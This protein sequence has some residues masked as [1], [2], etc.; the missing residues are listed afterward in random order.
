[1]PEIYGDIRLVYS[2]YANRAYCLN[3]LAGDAVFSVEQTIEQGK[4]IQDGDTLNIPLNY[5]EAL[6]YN[7]LIAH[8]KARNGYYQKAYF[9]ITSYEY[10]NAEVCAITIELDSVETFINFIDRCE[11]RLKRAHAPRLLRKTIRRTTGYAYKYIISPDLFYTEDDPV[12]NYALVDKEI[13]D[14]GEYSGGSAHRNA[15]LLVLNLAESQ[16]QNLK[17]SNRSGQVGSKYQICCNPKITVPFSD[18]SQALDNYYWQFSSWHAP[19]E[20]YFSGNLSRPGTPYAWFATQTYLDFEWSE[21][22]SVENVITTKNDL[23]L[24]TAGNTQLIALIITFDRDSEEF[25]LEGGGTAQTITIR[26]GLDAL[27]WF[28]PLLADKIV[29]AVSIP[30]FYENGGNTDGLVSL[31]VKLGMARVSTETDGSEP[32]D[33]LD[34]VGGFSGLSPQT[35]IKAWLVKDLAN[36]SYYLNSA[37]YTQYLC[38]AIYRQNNFDLTYTLEDNRERSID[39]ELKLKLYPYHF[40]SVRYWGNNI[41]YKYQ[42]LAPV[43]FCDALYANTATSDAYFMFCPFYVIDPLASSPSMYGGYPAQLD[44]I[45]PMTADSSDIWTTI[46]TNVETLRDALINSGQRDT[47]FAASPL[48]GIGYVL[49]DTLGL[50]AVDDSNK[51]YLPSYAVYQDSY[52]EYQNY[53]K[54]LAVVQNE[55]AYR[56]AEITYNQSQTSSALN[57][58]SSLASAGLGVA[59]GGLLGGSSVVGAGS[60]IANS[61]SS[62]IYAGQTFDNQTAYIYNSQATKET[63]LAGKP[64]SQSGGTSGQNS[65]AFTG[66]FASEDGLNANKVIVSSYSYPLPVLTQLE[67]RFYRWGYSIP[68]DVSL[69]DDTRLSAIAGYKQYFCYIQFENVNTLTFSDPDDSGRLLVPSIYQADIAQ[70][71]C[72]GITFINIRDAGTDISSYQLDYSLDNQDMDAPTKPL[73]NRWWKGD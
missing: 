15:L 5:D 54:A 11:G 68:E 41:I 71:L 51:S 50:S 6:N 65:L 59:T 27:L 62:A 12:D 24:K 14:T 60:S 52:Q 53:S 23:I 28:G 13:A 42:E 3:L 46:N 43:L 38:N 17:V 61:I 72:Q 63:S 7:Y 4:F 40:S 18:G 31:D 37:T 22:E 55:Y 8:I 35:Q 69:E 45:L 58:V 47:Y 16:I 39:N 33:E 20:Y 56:N 9:F 48:L 26:W 49:R 73:F 64:P 25:S 66:M 10:K 57:I 32:E 67:Q 70:R 29:S 34:M 21:G 44:Y 2:P 36:L 19:N 30:N 1:M